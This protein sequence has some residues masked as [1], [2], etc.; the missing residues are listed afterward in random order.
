MKEGE[1]VGSN[2]DVYVFDYER[3][4]VE[5]VP[6]AKHLLLTGEM[7]PWWAEAARAMAAGYGL[8]SN[9]DEMIAALTARSGLDLDRYC[10]YLDP[11][12]GL[13]DSQPERYHAPRHV[14]RNEWDLRA[15]HSAECPMRRICAFHIQTREAGSYIVEEFNE[16]LADAVAA[17]CLGGNQF[18]GRSHTAFD[19]RTLLA[20]L[21]VDD[22]D[23]VHDLLEKLGRRGFVVG[24]LFSNGDGMH[25]WLNPDET[26]Q[27]LARLDA[28]PLPRYEATLAATDEQWRQFQEQHASM[29]RSDS[30]WD[31]LSL[32]FVR[33]VAVIAVGLRQGLLWGNDMPGLP[34]AGAEHVP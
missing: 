21:G 14:R 4:R 11:D 17:R 19:Y 34:D 33:T 22:H 18:V 5:I 30:A 27:L 6:A 9:A 7:A 16:A 12:L 25:G 10:T 26:Q 32:S 2:A 28:L 23:V 20:S 1:A 24:Y 13:R 29:A 31:A 15:C 3:Y 8:E